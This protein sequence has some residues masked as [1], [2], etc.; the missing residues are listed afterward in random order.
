MHAGAVKAKSYNFFK[1]KQYSY[2]MFIMKDEQNYYK[3]NG[4]AVHTIT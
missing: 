2:I 4:K 1:L 3:N